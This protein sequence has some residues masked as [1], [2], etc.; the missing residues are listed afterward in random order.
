M[1]LKL[2]WYGHS[3]FRLDDGERSVLV[4]PFI[5]G[6]PVATV[7]ADDINAE[8]ILLTHA[9][10]DHVGD[11]VEIANRN[12]ATVIATAELANFLG[13]Q[14]VENAVGANHGGTVSF[15]G[16]STKFVPAW[17]T[18]SYTT[19]DGVVAPGVPAGHV[20][21]FGGKTTY[22]AGDTC[23]FLDMQLI[24][25]EGLDVAVIPIGDHF[26]MGIKDAARAAGILKAG[27]V[28]PCHYNTFPPIRQDPQEFRAA[29]ESSTSSKVLIPAPG[30][31]V[32]LE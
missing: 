30:D 18:S 29:V 4:D 23:L 17:H 15:A 31:T 5:T 2:T 3:A 28:L 6:N 24:A 32:D 12:G 1:T 26:T 20:V 22:F 11:A 7:S 21:R 16:G 19:S 10:N 8:T 14:G 9:H 27:T 25:E 13:S